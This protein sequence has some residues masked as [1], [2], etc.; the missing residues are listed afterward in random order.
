MPSQTT[1][2]AF[3]TYVSHI[4]QTTAGW[5][6]GD[7]THWVKELAL[8]PPEILSFLKATQPKLWNEMFLLHGSNLE[9]F[10]ISALAKE[11]DTKGTLHILRYG[12]KFYGKTFQV[13]YFKPSHGLNAETLALYAKNQLT[14]TRQTPC[15]PK[16]N[17]TVDLLFSINGLPI[18][19]CELKNPSTG[20]D[21]KK[22]IKQ[23]KEGREPTAPLF[24][25]KTRSLVHFAADPDE[26]HMTTRL[27]K[28]STRFL[29]FNR[30]SHPGEIQ[31]GAGNPQHSS[32][33]RTGYFWEEVLQRDSFL[34]LVG[35]FL[36][37]EK[38]EEKVVDKDGRAKKEIKETLVF[39]RYHQLD[40]VRK[41]IQSAQREKVG[42]NYLIQH[43]AGSGKT[44]SISWL[45]H[46][47]ASLHTAEDEK[48]FDCVIVITDRR[49][50]DQHLQEAVYQIEHA[51]GVVKAI[52]QDSR[53]LAKALVDGTK[54][55]VTTLQKFPFV[56]SGL[57]RLAGA[58][59]LDQIDEETQSKA[60][61]WEKAISKRR[62]AL[63]IDE[64]HSSQSGDA[65]REMKKLLGYSTRDIEEE[66]D[67]EDGLNETMRSSLGKQKNLSIFAFTATPKGKTLE[68]FGQPG[69]T[70]KPEA[71]HT[72]SMRQA[73][74]EKFILDV[75]SNYT[76]YKTFYHFVKQA[77]G[78][79]EV[80]KKEAV[81][82]IA[83]MAL[84]HPTNVEQKV[85]VMVE[86]FHANVRHRIGSKAKAMVVTNSRIQAVRYKLAFDR[87]IKEREYLDIHALVAFSG[88]V[89]DPETGTDYTEPGMNPDVVTQK[90]I[91]ESALPERF[92][93]TEYQILIAANKY[94][95]GFDQPLLHTMYVDKRLD[96][97][98]AVQTLSRLN[99]TAPGK[100]E[101]FILDFINE[102]QEIYEAFKPYYDTTL[103][104]ET[105]DPQ[106]L[107]ILKHEL[108]QA[109]V[110]HWSEVEA[111]AKIF[112]KPVRLQ[113]ASDHAEMEKYF[114]PASDRFKAIKDPE[115]QKSFRDN[116]GGFVRL[117]TF[118]GQIIPYG[119]TD[120]EMLFSFAKLL[121]RK[122]HVDS[123]TGWLD[124]QDEVSL[125]Y[126]RLQRISS[127]P[128]DLSGGEAVTVKSPTD[129]G[130][131]KA[132]DQKAPLSAV[133]AVLND[134]FGTDFTE[135]DRLFLEQ[136]KEKASKDE[137]VIQTAMANP[138][139][140]Y[141]I[142]IR[143]RVENLLI[144]R[145]GENDKM[146]T[147]YVE[148][149]D[150]QNVI[151]DGLAD[152]IYES[153]KASHS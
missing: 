99:R 130:T 120:L 64:A 117:Y 151:F 107:E 78:D 135:E 1:E 138:K 118:L 7:K 144:Q 41:L 79:P 47:L 63:I 92:N 93:S 69:V 16:N 85:A 22:A 34:D 90:P 134:R 152:D 58:E 51:Q 68:L 14:V 83:K 59:D 137:Q 40:S 115:D 102:P 71:F 96:N 125:Q 73:I 19:T 76:T 37:V 129:V 109:Q 149:Q 114:Q 122:L 28:A 4:L 42:Q 65:A 77:S 105:S 80:K 89:H 10:L 25:F 146:V 32:G 12:F 60:R 139:D 67:W 136:I 86:H 33:Y 49:S 56:L 148:D 13:A 123:Q 72:Y 27:A 31:C 53:Q 45:S 29:P 142:G 39:P 140:K 128:I 84:M 95:T 141:K 9:S 104:A 2:K 62:Y 82:V 113:A 61:E 87:Y 100:E 5:T 57:L 38:K 50:L 132:T 106:Q 36:F 17:D 23:Y 74:E 15:H 112:Y 54:V 46:R 97:V 131:G 94:Q 153:V 103:L 24:K 44:N 20:Q 81:K 143:K 126:Y 133:I 48:V 75:L 88:T 70:G 111:F 52:D 127:G 91:S 98:Q 6:T 43:S 119:D 124:L 121:A 26:V 11:L 35:N 150:F 110:Y 8:F 108:D 18:A 3:E 66:Y 21:W 30:G 147:R 145:L 101:T 55:V 116:L